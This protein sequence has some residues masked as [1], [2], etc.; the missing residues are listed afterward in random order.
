MN[1]CFYNE[2]R[3]SPTSGGIERV[4]DTIA[5]NLTKLYGYKCY[6]IYEK[7]AR[8][9]DASNAFV[10]S[11]QVPDCGREI[12]KVAEL[13]KKWEIDILINQVSFAKSS[14]FAEA[15]KRV[16]AK[17]VFCLHFNPGWGFSSVSF[18]N[19]LR[20]ARRDPSL[21]NYL[22]LLFLPLVKS[23]YILSY[24]KQYA[25]VY[26]KADCVVLLSKGFIPQ[27]M[28]FSRGG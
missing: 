25:L 19:M 12:D 27:F 16:G 10:E 17:Q 23:R 9:G 4:T 21:K 20:N 5:R 18:K 3:I 22:K 15:V 28:E 7:E 14:A 13:F 2:L 24:S 6:N 1:I 26:A 11:V 8:W